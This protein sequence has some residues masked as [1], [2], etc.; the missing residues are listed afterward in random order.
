M[1]SFLQVNDS[2]QEVLAA[3]SQEIFA[4]MLFAVSFYVFKLM[5]VKMGYQGPRKGK[6]VCAE[7]AAKPA[8]GSHSAHSR[9]GS[10][11]QRAEEAE[12]QILK[13]LEKHEF[14][15]ALNAY[16]SFEREGLDRFFKC[17]KMYSA[18]I[19]SAIR[20][21]KIDVV[22]RMLKAM[23]RNFMVPSSDFWLSTLKMLSSRK[24]YSHCLMV[25]ATY[26]HMLPDDKVIF[27]CLIN[28][29]LESGTPEKA[30]VMLSR[31]QQCDLEPCDHVTAFRIYVAIGDI[32]A[33][34]KLCL[35]L[36]AK[37]TPLMLNL[38]LLA[39]INAKQP[40][41]AMRLLSQAHS[42]ETDQVK[43][44][45]TI[46]YN[47]VIKGFVASGDAKS[48]MQCLESL[49]AHNLRTDDVTLTSLLEISLNDK[50][51]VFAD[52]VVGML[53][54]GADHGSLDVG[55]CNTFIKA[56]VR[57][58]RLPKAFEV[59]DGLK[60]HNGSRPNIIT[61]SMLI[62]AC[63]DAQ[64]LERAL[65]IVQDMT[66]AGMPPD[67]IIFTHL[68][69]GCR[70]V[71]NRV[72]GE[73]LF[74][75][76][77]AAGVKPSDYTLTML[78]KL[79]GRCGAHEKAYELV[80]SW[81]A[82]HAMKPSVIHYTCVMSGCLRNKSHSLA[83]A[84]YELMEKQGVV[85]DETTMS[86]LL[87]AMVS[88][89]AWDRVLHLTRRALRGSGGIK[90]PAATLNTALAQML[91]AED[92]KEQAKEMKLLMQSAGIELTSRAAVCKSGPRPWD[93]A[94]GPGSMGQGP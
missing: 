47:T 72:L 16:R 93:R 29:A 11:Q 33:A 41:R 7:T 1:L 89:Q 45:D 90:V 24:H 67:E 54:E 3:A 80:K 17:E 83:W 82:K 4:L 6:Q 61:Y 14:T 31:Y 23:T 94:P 51:G 53:L 58:D 52:R 28:A 74:Q 32:D 81:E 75:D 62:R 65:C 48:C 55:T 25:F 78:V 20:V 39:C 59:Y 19:Q 36:G 73:H 27:S 38:V 79:Y 88:L 60:R 46:S 49:H 86:T 40:Q 26:G 87:P 91:A 5:N 2:I 35:E 76:M 42:R 71:G 43:L 44:V 57:F 9:G 66:A 70:L 10:L 37:L 50:V 18:F 30:S 85:P 64:D 77:L 21:G 8:T 34:E 68:L 15:A 92:A 56:L 63:V 69:E 84:S 12:A 22:D 13:R